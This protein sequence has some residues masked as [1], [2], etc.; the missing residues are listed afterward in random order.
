MA[1]RD[2]TPTAGDLPGIVDAWEYELS[3]LSLAFH[4][5]ADLADDESSEIAFYKNAMV[6]TFLVHAR[7]LIVFY[8]D[9]PRRDDVIA[10]DVAGHGWLDTDGERQLDRLRDGLPTIHMWLAHLTLTRVRETKPRHRADLIHA[11]LMRVSRAF[12]EALPPELTQ[13][14]GQEVKH[15]GST[16][17]MVL[18]T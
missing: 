17:D 8:G 7:N 6:E 12:V 3:M 18:G 13:R 5:L 9:E 4:E 2:V 15:S 16:E 14:I 11:R 1:K 10:A